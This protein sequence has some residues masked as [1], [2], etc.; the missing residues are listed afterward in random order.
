MYCELAQALLC[1]C[2]RNTWLRW[3]SQD[4]WHFFHPH[5]V[6]CGYENVFIDIFAI[7]RVSFF[8][9]S[10]QAVIEYR[11]IASIKYIR[12]KIDWQ[13][14]M[15]MI[16]KVNDTKNDLDNIR[17]SHENVSLSYHLLLKSLRYW[18]ELQIATFELQTF[19]SKNI[20]IK[21]LN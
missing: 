8:R 6:T 18:F 20:W 3:S 17:L 14:K 5:P 13:K 16:W 21:I 15:K 1:Q 19:G 9:V 7:F 12:E 2:K 11:K 4:F 10:E